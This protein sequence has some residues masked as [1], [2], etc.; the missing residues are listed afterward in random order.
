[1]LAREL[2]I[3]PTEL[4]QLLDR[5]AATA[6]QAIDPSARAYLQTFPSFADACSEL[7]DGVLEG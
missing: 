1:M 3:E 2:N 5:Y 7:G 6:T 4:P